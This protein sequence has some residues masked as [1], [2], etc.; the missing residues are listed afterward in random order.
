MV[1]HNTP[2]EEISAMDKIARLHKLF[3]QRE[4]EIDFLKIVME[5]RA[6]FFL[7]VRR[8]SW[9]FLRYTNSKNRV[10]QFQQKLSDVVSSYQARTSLNFASS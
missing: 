1:C 6:S 3:R 4:P 5:A 2:A 7:K 9:T 10:H 8:F